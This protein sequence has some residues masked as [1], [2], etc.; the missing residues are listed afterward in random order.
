MGGNLVRCH[1]RVAGS[2]S[3]STFQSST[4]LGKVRGTD[5]ITVAIRTTSAFPQERPF[6]LGGC[7]PASEDCFMNVS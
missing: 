7:L 5:Q 3:G 4:T 2:L 1:S 6:C